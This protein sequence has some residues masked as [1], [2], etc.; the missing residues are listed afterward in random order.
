MPKFASD[1]RYTKV[2]LET[3]LNVIISGTNLHYDRILFESTLAVTVG[4]QQFPIIIFATDHPYSGFKKAYLEIKTAPISLQNAAAINTKITNAIKATFKNFRACKGNEMAARFNK[5]LLNQGCK[6]GYFIKAVDPDAPAFTFA[7]GSGFLNK[8]RQVNVS[9][10]FVDICSEDGII[11]GR[12]WPNS[13]RNGGDSIPKRKFRAATRCATAI[14]AR[15]PAIKPSGATRDLRKVRSL[16]TLFFFNALVVVEA[17]HVG[18]GN[19]ANKDSWAW[20]PKIRISQ[21][22]A[23][24]LSP[25]DK[26]YCMR[27]WRDLAANRVGFLNTIALTLN[28]FNFL[29]NNPDEF[30]DSLRALLYFAEYE[31]PDEN[32]EIKDFDIHTF[33]DSRISSLGDTITGK[34]IAPYKAP[35]VAAP[36]QATPN[37]SSY[38]VVFEIRKIGEDKGEFAHQ[39]AW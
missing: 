37:H 32:W 21:A 2:G 3:E 13:A 24:I 30:Y 31:T 4:G 35:I 29:V 39:F 8:G 26:E 25:D 7:V 15:I 11:M 16:L 9:V 28:P 20:L 10:P 1:T 17:N 5:E 38:L 22:K 6:N 27:L 23:V 14:C 19:T 12:P 33:D 18:H 36:G 34:P